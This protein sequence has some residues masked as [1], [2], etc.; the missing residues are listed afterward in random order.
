MADSKLV[1]QT[2]SHVSGCSNNT[3]VT[4]DFLTNAGDKTRGSSLSQ[5]TSFDCLRIVRQSYE[6]QGFSQKATSII[7]QSWRQG[8]TKQYSSFRYIKRWTTYC[9]QKQ[10]DT[11]SATVP[12]AL[13]FLVETGVGYS[14]LNTARSAR[15]TV[16]KP[17]NGL[18]FGAL[19]SVKKF[20]KGVY[21]ARP[22]NPRYTVTWEVNKVLNYLKST[23]R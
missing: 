2:P 12:Q 6:T 3:S 15:S 23:S 5:E 10:I 13:D 17:D 14:A 18:T 8:T 22:S 19:Q 9:R 20:L 16:L 1:P 7:L 11:V 21:E 4:T